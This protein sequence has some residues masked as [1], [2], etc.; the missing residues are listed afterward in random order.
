MIFPILVSIVAL[1]AIWRGF[2]R[3][4][5]R[6]I[7]LM[8]FLAWMVSWVAVAVLSFVPQ[9]TDRITQ[10]LG[11]GRGVDLLFF[12]AILTLLYCVFLL[13]VRITQQKQELTRLVRELALRDL[14]VP[15]DSP[16][17][18]QRSDQPRDAG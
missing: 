18:Q 17:A 7:P 5:D 9:V 8:L 14:H 12:V 6:Q 3:L 4:R 2:M 11:V 15:S 1:V 16:A 10:S 13:Y